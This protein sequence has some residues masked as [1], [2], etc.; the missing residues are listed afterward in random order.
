MPTV[1]EVLRTGPVLSEASIFERLRRTPGIEFDPEVGI[2]ALVTDSR[3]QPALWEIHRGYLEAGSQI[4]MTNT[5]GCNRLR[6]ALQEPS[7]FLTFLT[8]IGGISAA[9]AMIIVESLALAAMCLNHL[10]LPLW[11][12]NGGGQ[13]PN[14]YGRLLWSRRLLIALVIFTGYASYLSVQNTQGLV[15]L[16]LTS[17]VA[18][19]Q[20]LPAVIAMFAWPRATRAGFIAGTSGGMLLWFLALVLPLITGK[21]S[22]LSNW[23]LQELG[24]WT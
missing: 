8:F 23:P 15:Q 21:P 19:T 7:G 2:G 22:P 17:F 9:S 16:G 24:I 20:F 12:R 5:F 10:I 13:S 14:F 4:V 18:V 11:L 6:L 3:W 1:E